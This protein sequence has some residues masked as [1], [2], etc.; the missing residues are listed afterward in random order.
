MK[1][2]ILT[3]GFRGEAR[4]G[5]EE[6]VVSFKNGEHGAKKSMKMP[7]GQECFCDHEISW[8]QVDLAYQRGKTGL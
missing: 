2:R 5:R 8:I 1:T 6:T 7:I 4:V 3:E